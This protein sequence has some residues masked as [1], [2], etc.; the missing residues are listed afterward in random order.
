MAAYN[1]LLK[2]APAKYSEVYAYT[3]PDASLFYHDVGFSDKQ[4]SASLYPPESN[5]NKIYRPKD[6]A[7]VLLDSVS[8]QK[9]DDGR[10]NL[11]F[12]LAYPGYRNLWEVM[13]IILRK[14]EMISGNMLIKSQE[15]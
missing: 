2:D 10:L 12:S 4:F 15:I 14:P 5:P 9:L 6:F 8:Q 1:A 11:R 3:F 13:D 7:Y